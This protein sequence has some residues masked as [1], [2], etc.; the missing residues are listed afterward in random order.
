VRRVGDELALALH[1]LLGLGPRLVQRAQHVLERAA[2]LGDLV[3]AGQ[4][5]HL[6][7]RVAG[8]GDLAR[9]R[10]ER[11]DRPHRAHRDGQP[12]EVGEHRADEHTGRE[13]QP[14]PVDRGLD[15]LVVLRVLDKEGKPDLA[16]RDLGGR[17][18]IRT[19]GSDLLGI[20]WAEVGAVRR[21]RIE[22]SAG[23]VDHTEVITFGH[24]GP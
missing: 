13:E 6:A 5:R 4:G 22:L 24:Q 7:R 11:R 9:R 18:L 14:Q 2:K 12:G 19:D 1:R 10:R 20:R 8:R 15:I 3:V 16:C 21:H 23:G 17:D